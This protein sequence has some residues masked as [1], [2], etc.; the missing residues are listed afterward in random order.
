MITAVHTLLYAED[1]DAARAF[2]R[3]VLRLPYAD[4]GGGWLIFKSGPS[5]MGVHPAS[6]E[7]EGHSGATD[8]RFDV[9]LMCDDLA[10]TMA[11]LESRGAEFDGEVQDEQWGR[12][13]SLKVPGAGT[14]MLFEPTYDPPATAG[15]QHA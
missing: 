4:T 8:Q 15:P 12:T 13:V 11:D 10:A 14:M 7:H 2:L 1:P 6:W 5:E 3:D 9:S